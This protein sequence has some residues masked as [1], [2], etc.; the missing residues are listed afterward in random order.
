MAG[1]EEAIGRPPDQKEF[2][3][4]TPQEFV[5][6]FGGNKVI[7]RVGREKLIVQDLIVK[8][9]CKIVTVNETVVIRY[10]KLFQILIANNGIAA[11]KCMRSIRK[12]A[13]EV[14]RNDRAFHFI[15]M[16]TPEDLKGI[17]K[18]ILYCNC[19]EIYCI[20][21]HMHICKCVQYFLKFDLYS[22]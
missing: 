9:L 10:F 1:V 3:V 6:K 8:Y 20:C 5:K 11:V 12:W 21:A 4:A 22:R 17:C 15:G 16:V 19:R 14:F 7:T 13:Y 2:N 18:M